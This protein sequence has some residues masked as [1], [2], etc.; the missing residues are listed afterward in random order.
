MAKAQVDKNKCLGCGAC[1]ST[2]PIGAITIGPD[3]K[4]TIDADKCVG[5]GSCAGVCPAKA[6]EVK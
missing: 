6:I 3:G 5:C 4:A 1:T 2:C